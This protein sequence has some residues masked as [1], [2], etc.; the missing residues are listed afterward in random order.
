MTSLTFT[1]VHDLQSVMTISV[2]DHKILSFCH[3]YGPKSINIH[4]VRSKCH[5]L[6]F[7][8]IMLYIYFIWCSNTL[9]INTYDTDPFLWKAIY[10]NNVPFDSLTLPIFLALL[11]PILKGWE[12]TV[13]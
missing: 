9:S 3:K 10:D 8:I 7:W 13:F 2:D 12:Q 4:Y 1:R 5:V 6:M 11:D